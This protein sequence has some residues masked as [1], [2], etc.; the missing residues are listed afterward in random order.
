[1]PLLNFWKIQALTRLGL[2]L[3]I[4]LLATGCRQNNSTSSTQSHTGQMVM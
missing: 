4:S 2:A 3:G 1:M